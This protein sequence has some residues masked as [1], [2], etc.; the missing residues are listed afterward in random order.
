MKQN[1]S[2]L[3]DIEEL[4]DQADEDRDDCISLIEFRGLMLTLDRAMRDEAVATAFL[5]LDANHDGRVGFD[6]FRS[7]WLKS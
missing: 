4:F 1:D 7:W 6:E 3:D 2:R 5:Q